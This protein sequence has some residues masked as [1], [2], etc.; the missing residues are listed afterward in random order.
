[1]FKIPNIF[2]VGLLVVVIGI[3]IY[4]FIMML[5]P[6]RRGK[7][8]SRQV[9]SMKEMMQFS[10]DDL[11]AL[12]QVGLEAKKKILDNNE[13][14]LKELNKRDA[15][16]EAAGIKTKARAFK[17]GFAEGAMFC[18]HCG[19]MIDEDSKFCKKCGKEQ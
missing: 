12:T 4:V 6:K 11:S 1:M 19:A 9:K 5:S 3:M 13:D 7:M 10:S 17:E 8:L 15:E 2:F 18:K 16:I 14:L